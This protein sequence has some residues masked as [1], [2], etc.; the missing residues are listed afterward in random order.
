[1]RRSFDSLR[2]FYCMI[3]TGDH[4][5]Q[6]RL[7]Y[8]QDDSIVRNLHRTIVGR[9]LAPA[10][11]IRCG[12]AAGASPRPTGNNLVG[13]K[14]FPI[15][16]REYIPADCVPTSSTVR[17]SGTCPDIEGRGGSK[18]PPYGGVRRS[19]RACVGAGF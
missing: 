6:I 9:G 18:P 10:V 1:M 14:C 3:A 7:R 16:G 17:S 2:I 19:G 8:A 4:Y 13:A 15:V 5:I 11:L 12:F